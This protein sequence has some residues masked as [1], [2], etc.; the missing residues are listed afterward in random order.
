MPDG[1]SGFECAGGRFR[2]DSEWPVMRELIGFFKWLGVLPV[3]LYTLV[4]R[5]SV[6][7]VV[8]RYPT[9]VSN[10][11]MMERLDGR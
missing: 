8:T 4:P 6:S 5:R 7:L 10:P 11:S 2:I 3:L 9:L 1:A